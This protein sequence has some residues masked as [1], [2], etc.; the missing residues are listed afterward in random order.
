LFR[1][2]DDGPASFGEYILDSNS[3]WQTQAMTRCSLQ[4]EPLRERIS[5]IRREFNIRDD[6]MVVM[7]RAE[8]AEEVIS[9]ATRRGGGEFRVQVHDM[10]SDR[11][12]RGDTPTRLTLR[13]T[14]AAAPRQLN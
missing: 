11:F 5:T 7:F 14:P 3:F 10:R 12:Y 8:M 6:E 9:D 2:R 13:S 1:A 4:E